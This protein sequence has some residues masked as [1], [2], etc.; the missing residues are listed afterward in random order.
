MTDIDGRVV[1]WNAGTAQLLGYAAD[2]V[3]GQFA[4]IFFTEEDQAAGAQPRRCEPRETPAR[5]RTFAGTSAKAASDSLS[6]AC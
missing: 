2:E 3:L 6:M 4:T 5:P 1:S